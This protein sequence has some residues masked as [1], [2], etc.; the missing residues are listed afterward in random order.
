M[1]LGLGSTGNGEG[2]AFLPLA[3]YDARSG[4]FSIVQRSQDAMGVW[5]SD[6]TD[7]TRDQPQF[8]ID[9]GSTYGLWT[10]YDAAGS[11]SWSQTHPLSP[12]KIAIGD[13]DG[14]GR[15]DLI[16]SFAG[17]GTFAYMN[18]TSWVALHSLEATNLLT[19]DIDGNG[20]DDLV[21]TFVGYGTW[22]RYDSGGWAQL[23]AQVPD[24]TA[25]GNI[26]GG[27][28][29]KADVILI[30][31]GHFDH[32]SDAASVAQRTGAT[33][34][35][36]PV[37]NEVLKRQSLPERQIRT[38]TGKD[39]TLL[40]FDGFTVQPIL[41]LHGQPDRHITE[42]MEGALNSLTAKP[43]P[44]QEA[45]EK[46][47]RDRG[48]RRLHVDESDLRARD[49]SGEPRDETTDHASAN[50]HN[51]VAEAGGGIPQAV[52]RGLEVRR[53][54]RPFGRNPLRQRVDR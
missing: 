7:I 40:R 1:A 47:I 22:I 19:G 11:P 31:H 34:V 54:H 9:F 2:G 23:H 53:Q 4:R 28:G 24:A 16:A 17:Y 48:T 36:A 43:T 29:G 6:D 30:G 15:S 37:T 51:A 20:I 33:V 42:V 3:K 10:Y 46:A 50:D 49:A 14:N 5:S 52:D 39:D 25:V 26:D 44:E 41:G 8:V 38:V 18:G 12:T 45:E 32:M 21:A 27:P 13:L 35:G